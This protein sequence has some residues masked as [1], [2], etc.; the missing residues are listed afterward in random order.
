MHVCFNAGVGV[1]MREWVCV[2]GG[3]WS[4][5]KVMVMNVNESSV[6]VSM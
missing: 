6:S 2:L 5:E 4:G 3:L 1:C